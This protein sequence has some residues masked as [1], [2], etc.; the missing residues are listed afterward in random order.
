[1]LVGG[2]VAAKEEE[3]DGV[4]FGIGAGDGGGEE[5]GGVGGA[6][7][8]IDVGLVFDA[9]DFCAGVGFFAHFCF[10]AFEDDEGVALDFATL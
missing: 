5:F 3:G 4:V 2:G 7:A 10:A 6:G 1:M 9:D 8:T